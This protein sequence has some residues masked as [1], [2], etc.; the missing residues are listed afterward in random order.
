MTEIVQELNSR[1]LRTRKGT[2]F[3]SN[4]LNRLLKNK[5]YIGTYTYNNE[6]HIE[7]AVPPIIEEDLFYK[8]QELLKY[9][10]RAAAHKKAKV[11]YLL[12]EKL[13]CG[14][15]GTMM[16]GVCGRWSRSVRGKTHPR[17]ASEIRGPW[18]S[19]GWR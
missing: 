2:L 16:V 13:F 1:G 4:S 8:V 7:H 19:A 9:N 11:D 15:C 6:V 14:K 17:G 12:T 18:R 3:T 10:Q 5:K